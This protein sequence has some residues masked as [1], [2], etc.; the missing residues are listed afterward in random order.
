MDDDAHANT[1]RS[2]SKPHDDELTPVYREERVFTPPAAVVREANLSPR[3]LTAAQEL[4]RKDP[5][6]FWS[7]CARD[8]TWSQHPVETLRTNPAPNFSETVWFPESRANITVNCL[9]RHIMGVLRHKL[10]LIWESESG[11]IR[12]YTYFELYREVNAL[13]SSLRELS[14][15]KGDRVAVCMPPIPETVVT[16]LACARIGAVHCLV[17]SAYA[18]KVLR[19]R[20]RQLEAK[21]LVAADGFI[22]NGRRIDLARHVADA[23]DSP[24]CDC[25]DHVVMVRHVGGDTAGVTDPGRDI[26]LHELTAGMRDEAPPEP[27]APRDPL[28]IL[29]TSGSSGEPKGVVHG[30]AGYMVGVGKTAEWILDLKPTD[31]LWSAADLDWITGHSYGV[32]GPLL[33]GAA[34]LLYG[35]HPLY[36]RADRVWTM[37]DRHGV[38]VLYANPT[39]VR[40]LKRHGAAALPDRPLPTLRL[41]AS[42]GEPLDPDSSVWLRERAGG[43]LRPVLDTWWQTET[44]MIMLSGAPVSPLKPGAVGP[45]VPGVAASVRTAEGRPTPPDAGGRLVIDRPWPAMALGLWDDPTGLD[46]SWRAPEHTAASPAAERDTPPCCHTGDVASRDQDGH[47]IIHG[48]GDDVINVAGRRL[49]CA[50]LEHALASHPAVAEAVAVGAP[51]KLKGETV[52]LVVVLAPGY[53]P[54]GDDLEKEL[55]AHMRRELGPVAAIKAVEFRKTLPRTSTGKLLRRVLRPS[56]EGVVLEWGPDWEPEWG[57]Y[58]DFAAG[59]ANEPG[60]EPEPQLD[61]P[62]DAKSSP[63]GSAHAEHDSEDP[64]LL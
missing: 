11:E 38:S 19:R 29:H 33:C 51:D 46:A 22:R 47:F 48:R 35:G 7:G 20:I 62:A 4:G 39:L 1:P 64:T 44:G 26:W 41:M 27:M 30:H 49:G 52:K 31:I 2:G 40:M 8:F 16:M 15:A 54:Q 12:K 61:T 10:A 5:A 28:F 63:A 43:N 42:V 50:D 14:V 53:T 18:P 37:A 56:G 17:S 60:P 9:D 6:A 45:P 34:T 23:L 25:L 59:P 21:C 3:Q 32:Y 13:A 55:K 36:P 58:I 24:D 57:P